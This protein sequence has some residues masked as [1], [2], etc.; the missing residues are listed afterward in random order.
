MSRVRDLASIL[1]RTEAINTDNTALGTGSGSV[2]SATI[3]SIID[4][5]YIQT[6]ENNPTVDSATA[7][8]GYEF[9]RTFQS[10][11]TL[12]TSTGDQRFYF[13]NNTNLK[14]ILTTV[15]SA[16]T[17]SA[18]IAKIKKNDSAVT[19]T[20]TIPAGDTLVNQ[21]ST[22]TF[23][24]NDFI[25]VDITQVGSANKGSDLFCNMLFEKDVVEFFKTYY[26]NQNLSVYTGTQRFYMQSV[27]ILKNVEA[28]IKTAPVGA[29]VNINIVKNGSTTIKSISIADGQYSSG[30]NADTI[31]LAKD[32]Y[33]TVNVTQVGSTTPGADLYI[34]LTFNKG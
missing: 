6:R 33:L 21:S 11:G 14:T 12:E 28:Y 3:I 4:S 25:T 22:T 1:G 19:D 34:N 23:T 18:V 30:A 15:S 7:S 20:I 31:N 32:D 26:K 16:P 29:A 10:V 2:D 27:S 13:N 17:G 8:L 5:S 9:E 24:K